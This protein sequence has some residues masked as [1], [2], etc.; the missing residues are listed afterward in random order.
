MSE[1]IQNLV[2]CGAGLATAVAPRPQ[3][4]EPVSAELEETTIQEPER[5]K[6]ETLNPS[7]GATVGDEEGTPNP[8]RKATVRDEGETPNPPRK[9]TVGD[10]E[11]TL[12]PPR[13]ATVGDEEAT[14]NPSERVTAGHEEFI[15]EAD[16]RLPV[17]REDAA[18]A[19]TPSTKNRR[20]SSTP[21]M[22]QNNE[23]RPADLPKSIPPLRR[24]EVQQVSY[25]LGQQREA[26]TKSKI[27]FDLSP[28]RA[29]EGSL[30][31]EPGP[32]VLDKAQMIDRTASPKVL[33]RHHS[34]SIPW[35]ASLAASEERLIQV[36]IGTVEVRAIFPPTAP[37]HDAA[38]PARSC[39][40]LDDYLKRRDLGLL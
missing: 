21:V 18:S 27:E 4:F 13:K 39:L 15:G 30:H 6:E 2:L 19:A 36:R 38:P 14:L 1:F 5:D 28:S 37:Q 26:T 17:K 24:R 3:T 29:K 40:S 32:Q 12:T 8:S 22:L 10:E 20:I 31:H 23:F 35:Q 9:A 33:P 16:S 25:S 7:E 34:S 11:E